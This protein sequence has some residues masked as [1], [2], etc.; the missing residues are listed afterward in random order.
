MSAEHDARGGIGVV[1]GHDV[2]AMEDRAVVTFEIGILSRHLAAEA[3][4]LC[5][6]PLAAGIVALGVHVAW[7]KVALRLG[8]GVG[9]VRVEGRSHGCYLFCFFC[10]LGVVD[11]CRLCRPK[12][13]CQSSDHT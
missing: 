4:K 6:D 13:H 5:Y 7:S 11:R 3:L 8:V 1:A 10:I 2:H 12:G 9:R